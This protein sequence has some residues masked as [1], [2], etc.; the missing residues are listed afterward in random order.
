MQARHCY[1]LRPLH[2]SS[3]T[4]DSEISIKP[5][6]QPFA[7]PKYARLYRT[8]ICSHYCRD[9]SERKVCVLKKH[10][11]LTLQWRQ[12]QDSRAMRRR[13]MGRRLQ[14]FFEG[15]LIPR[16][17]RRDLLALPR[18][19]PRFDAGRRVDFGLTWET[20]ARGGLRT[21]AFAPGAFFRAGL[22]RFTW[23]RAALGRTALRGFTFARGGFL[24]AR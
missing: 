2:C 6:A 17:L 20:L 18:A 4:T 1:H 15:N 3:F 19:R 16:F 22:R 10:E 7:R 11:R 24:A 23:A 8:R 21:L 12:A 9:F 14:R 13:H 5:P